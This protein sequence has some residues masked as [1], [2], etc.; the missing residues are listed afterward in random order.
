[1]SNVLIRGLLVLAVL[2]AFSTSSYSEVVQVCDPATG[3]C[4]LIIIPDGG[5]FPLPI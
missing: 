3:Y 5:G 4:Q 2:V 1:M